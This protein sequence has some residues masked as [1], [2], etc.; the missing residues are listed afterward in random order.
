MKRLL[1][2]LPSLLLALAGCY[3]EPYAD[4]FISPSPAYV[5]E[6]IHFT[7]T[8]SNTDYVEWDMGDGTSA[9]AFNVSHFYYDPGSYHVNLSAYGRNGDVS[10]AS[11]VV[12]V[13]GSELEIVVREVL[14]E[15]YVE[16]ASVILY[17]N[18]G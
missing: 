8:S 1:I 13:I 3:R 4:A 14:D 10:V 16:G 18:S 17:T 15:Y 6:D 5:G 11:F 2:I 12:D 9:S 7:N